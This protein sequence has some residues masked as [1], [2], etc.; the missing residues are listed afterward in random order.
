[1]TLK[2]VKSLQ[3]SIYLRSIMDS[4]VQQKEEAADR[5]DQAKLAV[6]KKAKGIKRWPIESPGWYFLMS[7]L[8]LSSQDVRKNHQPGRD[9]PIEN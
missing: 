3:V 1:M 7:S 6:S 2:D 8:Y 9:V 5:L 4:Y